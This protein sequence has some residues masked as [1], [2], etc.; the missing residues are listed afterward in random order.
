MGLLNIL[1]TIENYGFYHPTM[2]WPIKQQGLLLI[3]LRNTPYINLR[4]TQVLAN[5]HVASYIFISIFPPFYPILLQ[6][7]PSDPHHRPYIWWVLPISDICNGHCSISDQSLNF[8]L[9]TP[10]HRMISHYSPADPHKNSWCLPS[11][12]VRI[13]VEHGHLQLIYPW[14]MVIF[15][16][17]LS[18]ADSISGK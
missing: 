10:V 18:L 13:A 3:F 12:Y 1:K 8:A 4:K 17:N 6:Y 5:V 2:A 16:S 11:G 9:F 14:N 7:I 15:D